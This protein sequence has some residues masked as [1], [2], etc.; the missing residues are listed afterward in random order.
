MSIFRHNRFRVCGIITF[1]GAACWRKDCKKHLI[2]YDVFI[3]IFMSAL[4][5][6]LADLMVNQTLG[7]MAHVTIAADD[8]DLPQLETAMNEDI[9][10]T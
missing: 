3:F 7:G 2:Y 9:R 5:G 6:G 4:I 8:R 10:R 1:G